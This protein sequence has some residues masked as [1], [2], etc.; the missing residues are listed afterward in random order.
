MGKEEELIQKCISVIIPAFNEETAIGPQVNEIRKVLASH[1]IEHEIIVADDGSE[2]LTIK[3]AIKAGASVLSLPENQGYGSALKAGI[4]FAK[5][6]TILII[7]GDKTYPADQIPN[8]IDKLETAD[9]VVGARIGGKV[10][11]P[12]IRRPAKWILGFLASRIAGKTIPD[13]N[14][15]LR[16]FRRECVKQYFHILPNG[17]SFTTTITLA[18][19]GDGYRV[20]YHPINYHKRVGKSKIAP[21][22][23]IDFII[24]V[25]RMAMLFQ[26]L[27]VF[28]PVAFMCIILGVVKVAFDIIGLLKRAE[29]FNWYLIFQPTLSTSAVLLLLM[30][31]QLLLVGMVSDGLLRRI[32]RSNGS[33]I[34][35]KTSSVFESESKKHVKE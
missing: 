27:K 15:G 25:L 26:P 11:I 17:F 5:Y 8:L 2:D 32:S 9:M 12:L 29:T 21:R 20:V 30:G 7:D 13:L 18:M 14:S 33:L 1:D 16:I 24:L 23:F 10:Y 34:P 3:Q 6:E 19:L 35:S 22:N 28:L 4:L 31:L